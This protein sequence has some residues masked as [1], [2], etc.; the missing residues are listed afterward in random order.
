[1]DFRINDCGCGGD[2]KRKCDYY[3][4]KECCAQCEPNHN[5]IGSPDDINCPCPCHSPNK[6][7]ERCLG[8]F[9]ENDYRTAY[10]ECIKPNCLCHSPKDVEL[11]RVLSELYLFWQREEQT[12]G[13]SWKQIESFITQ[14]YIQAKEEERERIRKAIDNLGS[15]ILKLGDKNIVVVSRDKVME[16]LSSLDGEKGEV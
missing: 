14:V 9:P 13:M 3:F 8:I 4:P 2:C 12:G 11:E 16:A 10:K 6:C 7:C 1:M 5:A 15:Y